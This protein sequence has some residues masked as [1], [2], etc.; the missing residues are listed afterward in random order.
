MSFIISIYFK[1]KSFTFGK[2]FYERVK[3]WNSTKAVFTILFYLLESIG[4]CSEIAE[5]DCGKVA[6]ISEAKVDKT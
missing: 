3:I 5:V 4:V 1:M 2:N 6:Y